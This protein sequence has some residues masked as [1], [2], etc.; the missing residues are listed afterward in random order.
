[1]SA[2]VSKLNN[3]LL[4]LCFLTFTA[5]LS[6]GANSSEKSTKTCCIQCSNSIPI[7]RVSKT[8]K[9]ER[10][11]LT[12]LRDKNTSME[13]FRSASRK[14]AALLVNK[15]IQILP[16]KSIEI[17]S[18]VG[19]CKGEFVN[20]QIE[21][22]SI[23]RSGDALLETFMEHFP[24][25]NVNKI[26]IQRDEETAK[27]CFIYKKLSPSIANGRYVVI[28]EPA[29]ATGGTIDMTVSLLKDLGVAEEKIIIASLIAAPEGLMD[30]SQ[31][32]PKINVAL[33]A[34]DESLNENKYIVPGLGDFGDRYFGTPH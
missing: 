25:A 3:A 29:I 16:S 22:V 7:L 24:K 13:D 4:T 12:Q 27:P 14:L 18:P 28:T 9:Y 6:A 11:L 30:L 20:P 33:T 17:E 8:G 23:M 26:L 1:M 21:L 5:S 34:L 31:K 10:I 19:R 32:Y 15:V 2:P